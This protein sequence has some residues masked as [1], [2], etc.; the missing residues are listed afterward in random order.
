VSVSTIS[1]VSFPFRHAS[2]LFTH[3]TAYLV[4]ST[5]TSDFFVLAQNRRNW[6]T[7]P[8]A[9]THN[10]QHQY[11]LSWTQPKSVLSSG[12]SITVLFPTHTVKYTF[13]NLTPN[14]PKNLYF[15]GTADNLVRT[16]AKNVHSTLQQLLVPT[17]RVTTDN[18]F[19]TIAKNVHGSQ[20]Q[21]YLYQQ[22]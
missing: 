1:A 5:Y 3:D 10:S 9:P 2:F 14:Y 12:L 17:S 7:R 20:Q 6:I 16:I 13:H 18:F 11:S 22:R 21:Y 8:T 19:C 4:T 15:R